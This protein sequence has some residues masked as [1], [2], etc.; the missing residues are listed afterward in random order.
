L[1]LIASLSRAHAERRLALVIGANPGWSH[2][3]PLRYA[4]TDAERVRD[5]LVS[6]AGFAGDDVALLRD[7]DTADVRAALAKLDRAA[8]AA[9]GEGSLVFVYYSGH[10]DDKYLHLRGE[11]PLSH[12]ELQDALR[13]SAATIKLAVIDACKSGAVTRKGGAPAVEFNVDVVT[14][15]LSGMVVLTS[16]GAD[17]LSQESRALAGSVF[18]HHL[19]SGLRGAADADSDQR[20]TVAEAYHYAYERTQADT[21]TTGALQ[22]P[23]FRYEL[24]GQGE[25]VLTELASGPQ[26]QLLLPRG[27]GVKYVVLDEHDW[28]LIAEARSEPDRDVVLA[29]APGR[30]HVKRVLEDRLE[31][32]GVVVRSGSR[33]ELERAPF[34]PAPLSSGILKGTPSALSPHEHHEWERTRAFGLLAEGQATAALN[35]F[36]RLLREQR[37]D[38]VAWRGRGRALIWMA[39]SYAQVSDRPNEERSLREAL[40]S[41]PS[42]S[43]DPEFQQRLRSF[44]QH[45]EEDRVASA[46]AYAAV[47]ERRARP[48]TGRRFGFGLELISARSLLGVSAT[49]VIRSY[50]FPSLVFDIVGLGFDANVAVA[51]MSGPWSPY[52]ALGGHA[53]MRR[54]GFN[55]DDIMGDSTIDGPDPELAHDLFSLHGRIEVGGQF[56]ASNGLIAELGVA[57]IAFPRHDGHVEATAFPVIHFGWLF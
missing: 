10:A 21:A 36:D 3:R 49:A 4:E 32:V 53:S 22:R 6:L 57:F 1:L 50:V 52:A 47:V 56:V 17:E 42:L 16:S 38:T 28:R 11:P 44:N 14:P 45:H 9:S 8:R 40:K 7:P 13:G 29:V 19:V 41:D 43:R 2:D 25:L 18:T 12:I 5:V 34:K 23:A 20:V 37:D 48:R 46:T 39:D 33:N 27:P 55:L 24:S 31:V 15:K 54:L 26:A 30:Y 51:P 35:L